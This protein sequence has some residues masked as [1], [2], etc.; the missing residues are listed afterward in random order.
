MATDGSPSQSAFA[1][2]APVTLSW[3]CGSA[4]SRSSALST[5][6]TRFVVVGALEIQPAAATRATMA[7][8]AR[9]GDLLNMRAL[10]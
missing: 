3:R 8:L 7:K 1:I 10:A 6:R 5:L 2:I 9:G 4:V